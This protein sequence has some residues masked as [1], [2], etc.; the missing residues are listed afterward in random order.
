[1][2]IGVVAVLL[3]GLTACGGQEE[4]QHNVY[5][6]LGKADG[7]PPAVQLVYAESYNY[8]SRYTTPG[9]NKRFIIRVRVLTTEKAGRHVAIHHRTSSG[10]W[11]DLPASYLR[12]GGSDTELWEATTQSPKFDEQFAVKYTI[13]NTTYWDN[14]NFQDYHLGDNDGPMLPQTTAVRL[15]EAFNTLYSGGVHVFEGT[16]YLRNLAYRKKVD[17]HF[18]S[19]DW[20]T[21]QVVSAG[22]MGPHLGNATH[23]LINNPNTHNIEGWYFEDVSN[24]DTTDA[25]TLKPIAFYVTYEVNGQVY[26]DDNYGQNY[27]VDTNQR[28]Q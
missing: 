11:V 8:Q 21:E 7:P 6:A 19:D 4:A 15:Q 18:S 3:V 20:A 9:P 26:R 14:N 23:A 10:D 22:Y 27:V 2:G 12:L 13:G 28:Y 24:T 16:V 17:I 5:V 25:S 1:V